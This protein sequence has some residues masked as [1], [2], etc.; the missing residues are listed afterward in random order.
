M[1]ALKRTR[2]ALKG[3]LCR[4]MNNFAEQNNSV[5][6][7]SDFALFYSLS[8]KHLLGVHCQSLCVS[9]TSLTQL[10]KD[11]MWGSITGTDTAP[12]SINALN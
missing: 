10:L 1:L 8:Y 3:V 12:L 4:P 5:L 6:E 7:L 2:E 11:M 9:G